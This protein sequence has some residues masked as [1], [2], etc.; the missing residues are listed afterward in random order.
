M[1]TLVRFFVT[2]F[3]QRMEE[4]FKQDSGGADTDFAA[5]VRHVSYACPLGQRCVRSNL[6]DI[7]LTG[8]EYNLC[9][10]SRHGTSIQG[11]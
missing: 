3:S 6:G 7:S 10:H 11:R 5:T 8:A 4:D 1:F 2:F 9:C